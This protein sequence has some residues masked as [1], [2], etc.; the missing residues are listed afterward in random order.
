[1]VK[2]SEVT[3][4]IKASIRLSHKNYYSRCIIWSYAY[5]FYLSVFFNHTNLLPQMLQQIT[6]QNIN[7]ALLR[8]EFQIQSR[9]LLKISLC[10][11]IA[12]WR[13]MEETELTRKKDFWYPHLFY[14]FFLK[15]LLKKKKSNKLSLELRDSG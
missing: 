14:L 8:F 9:Q 6:D 13:D 15:N 12:Y 7:N 5:A 3:S 2:F 4:Q 1:M 10:K 11:L